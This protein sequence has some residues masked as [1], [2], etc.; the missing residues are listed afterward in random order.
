[1]SSPVS[2]SDLRCAAIE[3]DFAQVAVLSRSF[4]PA[5]LRNLGLLRLP[6]SP[7]MRAMVTHIIDGGILSAWRATDSPTESLT[8]GRRGHRGPFE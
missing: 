4:A 5:A 3:D 6:L 8:D 1:M 7:E 2:T